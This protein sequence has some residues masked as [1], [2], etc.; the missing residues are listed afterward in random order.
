MKNSKLSMTKCK[1]F[2]LIIS[3][4]SVES[5]EELQKVF[6][7]NSTSVV[8]RLKSEIRKYLYKYFKTNRINL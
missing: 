4:A 1:V 2:S 3:L 8:L 7:T 6:L 5:R